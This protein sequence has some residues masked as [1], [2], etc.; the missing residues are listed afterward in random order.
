M[1]SRRIANLGIVLILFAFW[2]TLTTPLIRGSMDKDFLGFYVGARLAWQGEFT[3]MYDPAVLRQTQHEVYPQ[4]DYLNVFNRAPVFAVALSPLS[5]LP[6]PQAYAVWIGIQ[7]AIFL[8]CLAWAWRRFGDDALIWGALSLPAFLGIAHGQDTS[9]MLAIVIAG[10]AL[11]EKNRDFLAG[12]AWALGLIKFNLLLPL[13][14]AM[15]AARRWKMLAGFCSMGVLLAGWSC[16]LLRWEGIQRYVALLRNKDLPG[17]N[18]SPELMMNIEAIA[19][20][21]KLETMWFVVPATVAVLA[22]GFLGLRDAPLWRWTCVA[23]I[24]SLV[25]APHVYAYNATMLLLPVWLCY[26]HSTGRLTRIATTLSA[27]PLLYGLRF[28]GDAGAV[29]VPLALIACLA[30]LALEAARGPGRESHPTA[31]CAQQN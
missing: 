30:G 23:F 12:A 10:H 13:P 26:Y 1:S 4:Q 8:I 21:L 24:T 7:V 19:A 6:F 31:P 22:L 18:P 16:A 25:V 15:L 28:I 9:L 17:L 14:F 29:A 20:N 27:L 5:L 2:A 11:A 3:R